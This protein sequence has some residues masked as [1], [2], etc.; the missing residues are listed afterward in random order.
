[1]LTSTAA[2]PEPRVFRILVVEDNAGD[3]R[4][5]REAFRE[6]ATPHVIFVARDGEDALDFVHH[7]GKH[8][9]KPTPDLILLDLNLP[10]L[11]GHAVLRD[12]KA[13]PVL[14]SI[15]VLMFSSSSARLDVV[16]AYNEQAN[17]YLKKP[18]EIDGYFLIA[19][20]IERFW[21]GTAQMPALPS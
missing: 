7:R 6:V 16:V 10:R 5:V 11:D 15:V 4:L 3:V 13:H 17:A 18:L 14:R 1:M 21:F 12:I 8:P 2:N 20:A 19:K 9:D